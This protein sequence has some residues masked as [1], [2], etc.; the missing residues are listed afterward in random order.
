VTD[1]KSADVRQ[2]IV[3]EFDRTS[4]GSSMQHAHKISAIK[5]KGEHPRYTQ[6]KGANPPQATSQG[7]SGQP[8]RSK[9]WKGK[10]KQRANVADEISSPNTFTLAASAVQ[11][12]PQIALQPSRAAPNTSTIVSFNSNGQTYS[13][14]V[15]AGPSVY[16]GIPRTP[17]MFSMQEER[18]LLSRIGEKPTTQN[19]KQTAG[20]LREVTTDEAV[21]RLSRREKK[22][23]K[24]A[25]KAAKTIAT[26]G[27]PP[28]TLDKGKQRE[29][30]P[31]IVEVSDDEEDE[32][33]DK[34]CVHLS[35]D[36]M[37]VDHNVEIDWG[38][39]GVFDD[40]FDPSAIC[41]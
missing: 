19:L 1:V 32:P 20:V 21:D 24:R 13:K 40:H 18:S 30:T 7:Y 17:G 34:E 4:G 37:N 31:R 35:R 15:S 8:K 33:V 5:R 11:A 10:G 2:A 39:C 38:T 36:E 22:Q 6:Q 26:M 9:N 41:M 27:L 14:V 29:V 12:R 16:N 23:A 3:A 28:V 25:A